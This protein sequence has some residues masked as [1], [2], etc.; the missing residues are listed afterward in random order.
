VRN[1]LEIRQGAHGFNPVVDDHPKRKQFAFIH[2]VFELF[3]AF[4]AERI[5]SHKGV[6][7]AG[8]L[9][10]VDDQ[11]HQVKISPAVEMG[12]FPV[13]QLFDGSGQAFVD[14][15]D[16]DHIDLLS[17]QAYWFRF[18]VRSVAPFGD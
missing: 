13:L 3:D 15:C 11:T 1:L 2:P 9:E 10:N 5:G 16:K 4:L 7:R 12:C 14:L 17:D 8:L 6:C 18:A